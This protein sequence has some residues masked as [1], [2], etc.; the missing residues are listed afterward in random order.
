MAV[1]RRDPAARLRDGTRRRGT[2][3][4]RSSRWSR[5]ERPDRSAS[6]ADRSTDTER[7]EAEPDRPAPTGPY[8]V[9]RDP[10]PCQVPVGIASSAREP[11]GH[12]SRHPEL[13][14]PSARLR[15]RRR[16]G[17]ADVRSADRNARRSRDG[18]S[19]DRVQRVRADPVATW[20]TTSPGDAGYRAR[21]GSP[22]RLRAPRPCAGTRRRA[23][24]DV[25][26]RV[27]RRGA[28]RLGVANEPYARTPIGIDPEEGFAD[29]DHG[30][31]VSASEGGSSREVTRGCRAGAH[32]PGEVD[33]LWILD[34][35]GDDRDPRCDLHPGDTGRDLHAVA[36]REHVRGSS[37]STSGPR[38]WSVA[39]APS[40]WTTPRSTSWAA[41]GDVA[42]TMRWPRQSTQRRRPR[43]AVRGRREIH[44]VPHT[45]F[46]PV[47]SALRGRC[48]RPLD[49]C[50]LA[51]RRSRWTLGAEAA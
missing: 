10:A 20:S 14:K 40:T 16:A 29:C 26:V 25:T 31:R 43:G 5:R 6:R 22:P 8:V 12:P 45:G 15:W 19:R 2:A 50:G 37:R 39:T 34:V 32:G 38:S 30:D 11:T 18:R 41:R 4:R 17:P 23:A 24:V 21:R 13:P 42:R 49:E 33:E 47:I 36:G 9:T 7:R 51:A 35:D 46:E 28:S 44:L 1:R 48:P 3:G 27:R